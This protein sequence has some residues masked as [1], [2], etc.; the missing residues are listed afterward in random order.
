MPRR[1][2]SALQRTKQIHAEHW[3]AHEV[4]V[5]R[6]LNGDDGEWIQDNMS[7]VVGNQNDPNQVTSKVLIGKAQR[8]TLMRGIDSWT[9]TDEAGNELPWPPLTHNESEN[10]RIY[11]IRDKSISE[12]AP[13]DRA[14]IA[15]EIN[16]LN[17]PMSEEEENDFLGSAKSGSSAN[18]A[19]SH[20]RLSTVK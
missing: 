20:S 5:I 14:F 17:Q 8:F 11:R 9:F 16:K 19:G 13:E 10:T 1:K 12:L 7:E 4:V 18:H 15:T 3:D 6:A 2:G